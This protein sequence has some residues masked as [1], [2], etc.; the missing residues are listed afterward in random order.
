M[1][2]D[3]GTRIGIRSEEQ[4]A[5]EPGARAAGAARRP[6]LALRARTGDPQIAIPSH[7]PMLVESRP[8]FAG[9]PPGTA[10]SKEAAV[11]HLFGTSPHRNVSAGATALVGPC[12]RCLSRPRRGVRAAP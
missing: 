2:G 4:Y 8:S 9:F 1:M 3:E 12:A 5:T 11:V 6:P 7:L 10:G